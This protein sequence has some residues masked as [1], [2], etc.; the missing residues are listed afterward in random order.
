MLVSESVSEFLG[1]WGAYVPKNT[2]TFVSYCEGVTL[3]NPDNL[4]NNS[5]LLTILGRFCPVSQGGWVQQDQKGCLKM[6]WSFSW[7]ILTMTKQQSWTSTKDSWRTA[8]RASW[9]LTTSVRSTASA[10]PP[11][12]PRSSVDTSSGLLIVI[13]T[14]LLTSKS[15]FYQLM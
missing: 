6:T 1:Y 7:G 15:S 10:F 9:A 14:D 3:Q 13:R 5:T 11:G 8:R 2:L 4:L 12:M